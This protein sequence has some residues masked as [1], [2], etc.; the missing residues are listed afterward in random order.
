MFEYYEIPCGDFVPEM[1]EDELLRLLAG[2][3]EEP[4]FFIDLEDTE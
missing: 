3:E 4:E 2:E 1:T